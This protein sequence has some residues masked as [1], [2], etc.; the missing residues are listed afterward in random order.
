M[1]DPDFLAEASRLKLT[2]NPLGGDELQNLVAEVSN[3]S[4]DLVERVRAIYSQKE[5]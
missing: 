3:L 2:V 1:K 5:D 4:P